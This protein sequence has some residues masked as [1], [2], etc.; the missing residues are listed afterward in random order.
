M[1][2]VAI[3]LL[4]S[5]LVASA[6]GLHTGPH[7]HVVAGVLGVA[8]AAWLALMLVDETTRH[9]LITGLLAADACA[10]AGVSYLAA[11]GLTLNHAAAAHHS[12]GLHSPRALDGAMG[13]AVGE[14]TPEGIVRV[15]GEDW[16]ATSMNGVLHDGTAVQVIGVNGVRLEV[17][18]DVTHQLSS[19][20]YEP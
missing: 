15:R 12:P 17:W 4:A 20:G 1:W 7:A 2:F 3:T 11:R 19:E 14:L 6:V 10:A 18:G 9:V 16:S 13:V 5:V 8:T